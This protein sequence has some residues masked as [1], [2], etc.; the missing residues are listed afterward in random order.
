MGDPRGGFS[1]DPNLLESSQLSSTD[2]EL[3]FLQRNFHCFAVVFQKVENRKTDDL[4]FCVNTFE[5]VR[6][7]GSE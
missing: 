6:T 1:I 3:R 5:N 4:P 7:Y 2:G